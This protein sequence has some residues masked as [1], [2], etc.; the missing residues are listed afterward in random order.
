[1][2]SSYRL[3]KRQQRNIDTILASLARIESHLGIIAEDEDDTEELET[4]PRSPY[5]SYT[6]KELN[7]YADEAG[8]DLKGTSKKSDIIDAL[9]LAQFSESAVS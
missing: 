9:M 3:A 2:A 4:D 1:M 6:I 8:V 7:S 5:E